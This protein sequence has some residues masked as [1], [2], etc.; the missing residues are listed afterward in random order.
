MREVKSYRDLTVWNQAMDLVIVC[1]DLTSRLPKTE[2]YGLSSQI[3]R[4]VVSIPAN[5]AEGKGRL[6]LG[7]FALRQKFS[8]KL[9]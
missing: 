3:Q 9:K 7:A 8:V 2:I 1:Y 4:A 6:T 5:I